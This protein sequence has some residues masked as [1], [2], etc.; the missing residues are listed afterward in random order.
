MWQVWGTVKVHT[1]FWWGNMKEIDHLE[2]PGVGG[3]IILKLI[4]GKG[5]RLGLD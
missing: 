3:R 4:Q 2:D 1:E 5:W